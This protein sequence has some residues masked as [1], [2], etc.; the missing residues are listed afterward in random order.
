[1]IAL[2]TT[3]LLAGYLLWMAPLIAVCAVF[4]SARRHGLLLVT[5]A[6]I[7]GVTLLADNVYGQAADYG[8]LR[9]PG[10]AAFGVWILAI[11]LL[12]GRALDL[13]SLAAVAGRTLLA[14]ALVGQAAVVTWTLGDM[15][16]FA[17]EPAAPTQAQALFGLVM[18]GTALA[19]GMAS[20]CGVGPLR[21]AVEYAAAT[22]VAVSLLGPLFPGYAALPAGLAGELL[23][24]ATA[25][26][27]ALAFAAS[28]RHNAAT[29]GAALAFAFASP[30]G[31]AIIAQ[32]VTAWLSA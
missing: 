18:L 3:P 1:M 7:A 16:P 21:S 14:F 17:V 32:E 31:F 23:L 10:F 4:L 6:L 5:L 22:T 30:A 2:P 19:A 29:T 25:L 9:R 8:L 13:A 27:V 20:V 15:D 28:Q 24:A 26:L 12:L 11:A